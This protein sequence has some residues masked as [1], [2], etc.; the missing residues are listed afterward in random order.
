MFFF[1]MAGARSSW[2][3]PGPFEFPRLWL[4]SRIFLAG[5]ASGRDARRPHRFKKT[6]CPPNF[7][8]VFSYHTPGASERSLVSKTG[9]VWGSTKTACHGVVADKQ[10]TCPAS[11][12]MRERYPP[13]PPFHCGENEIQASLINSA[14]VGATP[15]PAANLGRC[16]GCR[17]V[18]PVSLTRAGSDDWSIT[19][20][21]HFIGSAA[22]SA[23]QPVACGKAGV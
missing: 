18:K 9:P 4:N 15:T 22:P 1:E 8:A 20:T 10:C 2:N 11:R 17:P 3:T 12:L 5:R 7:Q 19:S 21:S 14:S 6:V 13:A 16:S 23:G